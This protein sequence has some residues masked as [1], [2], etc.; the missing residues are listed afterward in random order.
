[1]ANELERS[2]RLIIKKECMEKISKENLKLF[3]KYKMDMEIRELSKGTIYGYEKD[4]K[5]W[6]GY[7]V[8][9]LDN[10]SILDLDEDDLEAFI[11]FCKTQGN[12]TE[13]IK[14]RMSSISAF[15]KFLRRKK[16]VKESPMEFINRPKRGLPVVVQTYLTI[17]QVEAIR[18]YTRDNKNL[19]LETYVELSLSTMARVNAISNISW[20][21]ID[22]NLLVITDVL[23][24]EGKIVDLFF[25]ER[26][27]K[28]L[29]ELYKER[30]SVGI[31]S[32]YVFIAM[33]D[34]KWDS[35]STN[36][37]RA[38]CKSIGDII[39]IPT[40]HPHDWRHSAATLKKNSG[41]DL[42]TVSTLLN[43]SGTDVTRKH[44]LKEDKTKL[45]AKS[46]EFSF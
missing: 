18:K 9:E 16:L 34:G 36:T 38:W 45:G 22:Y 14:R 20:E 43:H 8:Q 15:Y 30:M 11:Y 23:E 37:L 12:N 27:K 10:P 2:T 39:N 41:M 19:M 21:Q 40:L 31:Q 13:R 42:E 26:T 5:Q 33:V 6:M 32:P 29:Q 25:D 4:I 1:M 24:K 28:L 17:E 35:V 3:S 7:L 44:Y 46:R